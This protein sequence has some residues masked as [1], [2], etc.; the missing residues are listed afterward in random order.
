MPLRLEDIDKDCWQKLAI[1]AGK[2][3][4]DFHFLTLASVDLQSKPQ[5]RTVVLR[6][7]DPVNRVLEFHTDIRSTKWREL[8]NNPHVTVLGYENKTQLRMQGTVELHAGNSERAEAAWN[9]LSARTQKTYAGPAPGTD[10]SAETYPSGK[11]N[12]GVVLCR[13]NLLDWC[14][15]ARDSNQRALISYSAGGILASTKWVNA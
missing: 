14:L 12:F 1:G 9:L 7:V 4:A 5:A 11:V 15:L 8:A 10:L 13:V 2:P 6:G 3:D